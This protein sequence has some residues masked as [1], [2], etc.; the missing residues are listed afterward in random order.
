MSKIYQ[1]CGLA[2]RP[3]H[4]IHTAQ[5]PINNTGSLYLISEKYH[6]DD[7]IL[8]RRKK[9]MQNGLPTITGSTVTHYRLGKQPASRRSLIYA[10]LI[11]MKP[12]GSTG[13]WF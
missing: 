6:Q 11:L 10:H 13:Y 4:Q 9:T 12:I 3:V 2:V 8:S 5:T 7:Y 1:F